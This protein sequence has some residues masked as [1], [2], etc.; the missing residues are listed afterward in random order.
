MADDQWLAA[1]EGGHLIDLGTFTTGV[2][3]GS[4]RVHCLLR[5]SSDFSKKGS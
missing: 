5:Y 1:K 2:L 3:T 4:V